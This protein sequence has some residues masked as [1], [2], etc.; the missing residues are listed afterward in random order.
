VRLAAVA[1]A[2]L[3]DV[4]RDFRADRLACKLSEPV[5]LEHEALDKAAAAEDRSSGYI[6]R[7]ALVEWLKEKGFLKVRKFIDDYLASLSPAERREY[8]AAFAAFMTSLPDEKKNEILHEFFDET[9]NMIRANARHRGLVDQDGRS[10]RRQMADGN[11]PRIERVARA[12]C[13]ADHKDPD[14]EHETRERETSNPMEL[15]HKR[16]PNWQGFGYVKEATKFVAA[17]DAL[18]E[19]S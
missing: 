15:A 14:A 13:Q 1:D 16:I 11:D 17:Y 4:Q 7:R 2:R 10:E 18:H 12:L 9:M 19:N 6:A 5:E 3:I 8:E